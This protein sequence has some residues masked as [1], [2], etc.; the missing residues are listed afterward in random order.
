VIC[1]VIQSF[2]DIN[3]NEEYMLYIEAPFYFSKNFRRVTQI[4]IPNG[5][6][7]SNLEIK[8]FLRRYNKNGIY[9]IQTKD[10]CKIG[11]SR[12]IFTRFSTAYLKPWLNIDSIYFIHFP[13]VDYSYLSY[14]EQQVKLEYN[15]IKMDNSTEFFSGVEMQEI[16]DKIKYLFYTTTPE[17]NRLKKKPKFIKKYYKIP[18]TLMAVPS[19][20]EKI[21]INSYDPLA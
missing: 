17:S 10:G 6:C 13:N 2:R 4:K 8:S 18:P 7:H 16:S 15:S 1:D 14:I 19:I 20:E 9:I 12:N 11:I 21:V 5:Q 3:H